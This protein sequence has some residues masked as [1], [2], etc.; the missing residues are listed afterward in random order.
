MSPR[1]LRIGSA[2][3]LP[4]LVAVYIVAFA[5]ALPGL[6][7]AT[8]HPIWVMAVLAL[9]LVIV[10]VQELGEVRSEDPPLQGEATLGTWWAANGA[11]V[12]MILLLGGYVLA[13]GYLG[14]YVSSAIFTAAAISMLGYRRPPIIALIAGVTVLALWAVFGELLG[15]RL[16]SGPFGG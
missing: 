3:A 1:S 14:F 7:I 4:V 6:E 16:P 2:L 15:L 8:G 10:L 11:A 12:R 9:L 5:L 13:L